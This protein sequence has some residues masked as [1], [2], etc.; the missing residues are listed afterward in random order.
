MTSVDMTTSNESSPNGR[1]SALPCHEGF[2]RRGI[3]GPIEHPPR[4]IDPGDAAARCRGQ[5]RGVVAGTAAD[6]E[7]ARLRSE[8]DRLR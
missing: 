3:A 1:L 5:R 4:R 6:V 7:H 8:D 2:P